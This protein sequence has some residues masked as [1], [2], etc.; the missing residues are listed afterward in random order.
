M[1]NIVELY[2]CELVP[3]LLPEFIDPHITVHEDFHGTEFYIIEVDV[4]H[5]AVIESKRTGG[6]NGTKK[7]L[8]Q[9][10]ILN[11]VLMYSGKRPGS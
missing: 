11:P 1:N 9:L 10:G 8:S 4:S 3:D 6:A 2:Q 7:M 5:I